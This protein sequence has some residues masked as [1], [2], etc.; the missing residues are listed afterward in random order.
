MVPGAESNSAL[1][2]TLLCGTC[3]IMWKDADEDG[4]WDD[5]AWLPAGLDWALRE[6]SD[7]LGNATFGLV[8][9]EEHRERSRNPVEAVDDAL[10]KGGRGLSLVLTCWD[11][12]KCA[13]GCCTYESGDACLTDQ[14]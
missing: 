10:T 2:V 14:V 13:V 12:A 6:A 5:L 7:E 9:A 8:L 1:V 11:G 4:P 3:W